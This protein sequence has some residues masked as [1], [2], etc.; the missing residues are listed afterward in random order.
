[1]C[2]VT[3]RLALW[4]PPCSPLQSLARHPGAPSRPQRPASRGAYARQHLDTDER[5][6]WNSVSGGPSGGSPPTLL[7]I[8]VVT[9]QSPA[10]E[11]GRRPGQ[12]YCG[13]GLVSSLRLSSRHLEPTSPCRE[14]THRV[15]RWWDGSHGVGASGSFLRCRS[16]PCSAASLRA[17]PGQHLFSFPDNQCGWCSCPEAW[18]SGCS[19]AQVGRVVSSRLGWKWAG[20]DS[21]RGYGGHAS[22]AVTVGRGRPLHAHR[23]L[24]CVLR[25]LAPRSPLAAPSA[26]EPRAGPAGAGGVS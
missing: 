8:W 16:P 12:Q 11:G 23:N 3:R 18:A 14:A 6:F 10:S 2:S 9:Q 5:Y 4:V 22:P 21:V 25:P 17:G 15:V 19:P 24:L 7:A 1:M 20:R 13:V 26:V